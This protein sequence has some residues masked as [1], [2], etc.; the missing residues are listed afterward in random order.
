MKPYVADR[1]LQRLLG[2]KDAL[3]NKETI[4]KRFTCHKVALN[5]QPK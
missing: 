1:I 2:I 3:E 4:G 5:L